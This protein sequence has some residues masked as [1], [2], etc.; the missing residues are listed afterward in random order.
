MIPSNFWPEIDRLIMK[1]IREAGAFVAFAGA[2][3]A[4]KVK[5]K[6]V[7]DTVIGDELYAMLH[8]IPKVSDN[9]ELVCILIAGKPYVLGLNRRTALSSIEWD[10]PGIFPSLNT[11][12][13]SPVIVSN[14]ANTG[15]TTSTSVYA[16]NILIDDWDLGSGSWTVDGWGAGLYSHSSADGVVRERLMINADQGTALT[17]QCRADP[18]RTT[19]GIANQAANQTGV[20]DVSLDFRPNSSGTAYAGGGYLMAMARRES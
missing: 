3:S 4:G 18:V 6:R 20:I 5:V 1:R 13:F 19:I 17:T 16:N 12:A 10:L 14:S 9:D 7:G 8:G 15:S 2:R 11:P